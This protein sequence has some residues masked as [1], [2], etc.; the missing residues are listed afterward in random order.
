ML[1]AFD[2]NEQ[3]LEIS[4]VSGSCIFL[5]P[6]NPRAFRFPFSSSAFSHPSKV[7]FLFLSQDSYQPGTIFS[8]NHIVSRAGIE[9]GNTTWREHCDEEK[10][11]SWSFSKVLN[12]QQGA[13]KGSKGAE[14]ECD[15]WMSSK[16]ERAKLTGAW[17][18]EARFKG[19]PWFTQPWK[20]DCNQRKL[21]SWELKYKNQREVIQVGRVNKRR[22]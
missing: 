22:N 2:D 19:E 11:Q 7:H 20:I 9:L 16:W 17:W 15:F 4:S 12:P 21:E 3:R 6:P 14:D 1:S 13:R 18:L 5:L 8:L 10:E